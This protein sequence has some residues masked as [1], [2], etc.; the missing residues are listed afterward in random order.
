MCVPHAVT[1]LYRTTTL[2]IDSSQKSIME[3][4]RFVLHP[5]VLSKF[6]LVWA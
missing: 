3:F 6:G 5:P 2:F 1:H 4:L